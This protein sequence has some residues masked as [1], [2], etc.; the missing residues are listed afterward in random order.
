MAQVYGS[1]SVTAGNLGSA[2]RDPL[3]AAS[4]E[5]SRN[6]F[7][8][9][10]DRSKL[11]KKDTSHR[12]FAHYTVGMRSSDLS[13]GAFIPRGVV[14][15]KAAWVRGLLCLA[16]VTPVPFAAGVPQQQI[17]NGLPYPPP[18]P[19]VVP[20]SRTANPTADANRLM[21][22]SMKRQS[23]LKRFEEINLQRQ[24]EM[25]TDTAKLIELAH[26]LKTDTDKGTPEALAILEI[27][28]AE[29]IEKLAHSI[30]NKMRASVS[31]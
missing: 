12:S 30:Q 15:K 5:P 14:L 21:E 24:K 31:N 19:G 7:P 20:M 1:P 8:K 17:G 3:Y 13:F 25:T 23:D 2:I 27:R 6:L 26:Q 9:E 18:Q 4:R 16:L 28:R 10:P 29:L 22:D 11:L